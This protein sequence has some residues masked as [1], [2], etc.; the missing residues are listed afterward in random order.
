MITS[1][2]NTAVS[3]LQAAEK[4]LAN[5][6]NNVANVQSENFTPQRI[7]QTSTNPGVRSDVIDVDP[8][9]IPTPEGD[10]PNVDLA[11]EVIEQQLSTYDFKANLKVL[12]TA[13]EM[14]E[15]IL[16]MMA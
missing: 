7:T 16:D 10:A 8:A 1:I 14:A 4:R 12:E 3:G 11:S 9:R 5:S 15:D 2:I 13:D 6:A